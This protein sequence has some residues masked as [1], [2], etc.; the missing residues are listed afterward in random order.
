M[1]VLCRACALLV[2]GLLCEAQ[3]A[4]P[5]SQEAKTDLDDLDLGD[6]DAD[7]EDEGEEAGG[8]PAEDFDKD[9][10]EEDRSLRMKVCLGGAMQRLHS[11]AEAVSKLASQLVEQQPGMS[12]DQAG[13]FLTRLLWVF[14]RRMAHWARHGLALALLA[15]GFRLAVVPPLAPRRL[16]LLAPALAAG[17]GPAAAEVAI[18]P[19]QAGNE[20]RREKYKQ[21][22][23]ANAF[24]MAEYERAVA[25][26]KRQLFGRLFQ[27]L[28]T[29]AVVVE[30]GI[31][32]FPN[33]K[34]L[35]SKDAPSGMDIVGV[36]PN[37]YMKPYALD[38]AKR[39][40]LL[41]PERGNR[42]RLVQGVAEALPLEDAAAD[43]AAMQK[44]L[45]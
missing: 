42:L 2:L 32:S 16:A 10:P 41:V 15:L 28:P 5:Q 36:D 45:A 31:G 14:T 8:A 7:D 9:M 33:A 25:Q 34:Y 6:L 11:N 4:A 13:G 22:A 43:A 29:G 1:Q 20:P 30:V 17:P 19:R 18:S 38:N 40:N 24:G 27:S 21:F 3:D 12:K 39:A 35:S 37:E 44:A 23:K 26:K